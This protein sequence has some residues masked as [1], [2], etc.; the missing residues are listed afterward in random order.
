MEEPQGLEVDASQ[1]E[2]REMPLFASLA[3]AARLF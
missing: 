1:F 3:G 2:A